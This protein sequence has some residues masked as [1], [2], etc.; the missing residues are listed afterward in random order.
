MR[1]LFSLY[2][3]LYSVFHFCYQ[4]FL[5]FVEKNTKLL[6]DFSLP[7][8]PTE[9]NWLFIQIIDKNF[10][11]LTFFRLK[12]ICFLFLFIWL[13]DNDRHWERR[14]KYSDFS[15]KPIKK[16]VLWFNELTVSSNQDNFAPRTN[17]KHPVR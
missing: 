13:K 4:I 11:Q 9:N 17:K 2:Y 3:S 14:K 10:T 5:K 1:K 16:K 6:N 7:E 12:S 15:L 8:K